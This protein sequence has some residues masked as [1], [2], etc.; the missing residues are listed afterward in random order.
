MSEM[1][2]AWRHNA[3]VGESIP[4][5][6]P[7]MTLYTQRPWASLREENQVSGKKMEEREKQK[8]E[9]TMERKNWTLEG[10]EEQPSVSS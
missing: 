1:T 10:N 7:K 6:T 9:G 4:L 2:P 3:Q 5:I 8:D